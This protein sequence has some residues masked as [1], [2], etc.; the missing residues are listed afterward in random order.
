MS[1][2][3]PL[4]GLVL[5]GGASRRMQRDKAYIAYGDAPQLERAYRLLAPFVDRCFVSV[6]SIQRDDPLRSRFP[7]IVDGV[8][9]GGPAAGILAALEHDPLAGWL[10]VACDLPLLDQETL[11]RLVASRFEEGDAT[12]YLS[13]ADGQFEPLCAIWEASSRATLAACIARQDAS[14]RRALAQ[15]RVRPVQTG[16]HD[17]LAN[18]N[19]PE[20]VLRIR[21]A[22]ASRHR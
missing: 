18:A 16:R 2:R 10:V 19:T 3:K 17:A 13:E 8:Q 11:A 6:R 1:G 21:T 5:A 7:L 12:A 14:P 9:D 20:D 22:I 4:H 15:L